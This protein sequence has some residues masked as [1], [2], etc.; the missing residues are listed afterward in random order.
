MESKLPTTIV[1]ETIPPLKT[2]KRKKGAEELA[3]RP[4]NRYIKK[5]FKKRA[6]V[7]VKGSKKLHFSMASETVEVLHFFNIQFHEKVMQKWRT[8]AEE[9]NKKLMAEEDMAEI[10]KSMF[11][12]ATWDLHEFSTLAV[13]TYRRSLATT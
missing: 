1:G 11:P 12:N 4:F 2:K 6:P 5:V 3:P 8:H 9:N 10:F 13:E 7:V